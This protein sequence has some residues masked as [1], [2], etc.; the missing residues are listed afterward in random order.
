M[1]YSLYD[2]NSKIII[3]N[4][5]SVSFP[6]HHQIDILYSSIISNKI[7]IRIRLR[8]IVIRSIS[9]IESQKNNSKIYNILNIHESREKIEKALS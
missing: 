9:F 6:N 5:I 7:H 3:A 8:K 2:S 4:G 1:Q